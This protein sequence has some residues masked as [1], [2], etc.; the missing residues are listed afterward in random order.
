[1]NRVIVIK[2]GKGLTLYET[3]RRKIQEK[4]KILAN[5]FHA[6]QRTRSLVSGHVHGADFGLYVVGQYHNL[7]PKRK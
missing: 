6:G 1:M 2:I 3:D 4:S 7:M 5:Q